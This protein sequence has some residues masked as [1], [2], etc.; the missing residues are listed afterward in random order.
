MTLIRYVSVVLYAPE[1]ELIDFGT[2]STSPLENSCT[3]LCEL[4]AMFILH[5]FE[6]VFFV[7]PARKRLPQAEILAEILNSTPNFCNATAMGK[8]KY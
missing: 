8:L 4:S 1:C 5:Y 3:Y 2:P 6:A 7:P